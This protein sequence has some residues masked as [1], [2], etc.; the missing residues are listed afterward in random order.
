MSITIDR[1]QVASVYSGKY[2]C[3]C[4]CNGKHTYASR[5]R[6]WSSK[7]RGYPVGDDEVSD[8]TVA[9]VVNLVNAAL[10]GDTNI[11]GEIEDERDQD[12]RGYVALLLPKRQYIVYIARSATAESVT[13]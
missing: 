6:H 11:D 13:A 9:R 7:F 8:R 10:A 4:G 3:A 5:W 2:G 12:G 1:D